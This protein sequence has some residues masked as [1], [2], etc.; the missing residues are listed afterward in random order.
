MIQF[1]AH[2]NF[3]AGRFTNRS[4]A[5][6]NAAQHA[7]DQQIVKDSNYYVPKDTGELEASSLRSSQFGQGILI[8]DTKYA[9]R[10]YFNQS[11]H[12]SKDRNPNASPLWFEHGKTRHKNDWIEVAKQTYLSRIHE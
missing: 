10:L 11:A 8:W 9:K 4:Q 1:D 5:A 3:D 6:M 2:I 12:F 7:F